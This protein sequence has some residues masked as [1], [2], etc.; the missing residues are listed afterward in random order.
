MD[1][2]KTHAFLIIL[3]LYHTKSR[4]WMS[5]LQHKNKGTLISVPLASDKLSQR[6]KDNINHCCTSQVE[7]L[8]TTC[9][10]TPLGLCLFLWFCNCTSMLCA[11]RAAQVIK[12]Y[13]LLIKPLLYFHQMTNLPPTAQ[14][15]NIHCNER[16]ETGINVNNESDTFLKLV[17]NKSAAGL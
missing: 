4:V 1:K 16:K 7:S 17:K 9:N 15:E 3:S 2:A 5:Y 11:I 13:L 6:S 12:Y 14:N 8:M 10:T